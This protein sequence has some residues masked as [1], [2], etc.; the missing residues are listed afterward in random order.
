[1]SPLNPYLLCLH[2]WLNLIQVI[3]LQKSLLWFS[4][5]RGVGVEIIPVSL[6]FPALMVESVPFDSEAHGSSL[7]NAKIIILPFYT[8]R[9]KI[10]Q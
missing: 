7:D 4:L 6:V 3:W 1:M 5:V 2:F 10:K 8:R 9:T